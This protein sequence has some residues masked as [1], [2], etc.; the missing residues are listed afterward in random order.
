[1]ANAGYGF[2]TSQVAMVLTGAEDAPTLKARFSLVPGV[3]GGLGTSTLGGTFSK[4]ADYL[5]SIAGGARQGGKLAIATTAVA[6]SA[7]ATFATV[8]AGNT[9]VIGGV[10]FTG[11]DTTT[12]GVQF[13]TGTTDAISAA[14][15]AAKVV[16]ATSA[17]AVVTFTAIVPGVVGNFI[18][19]TATGVPITVT[20][21]GFLVSGAQDAWVTSNKGL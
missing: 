5:W 16:V 8:V 11:H 19:L 18:T 9:V 4:V 13:L 7:T 6:A 12:T 1:M 2:N 14:S 21:S 3:G 20:G 17:A 15:L 10:T